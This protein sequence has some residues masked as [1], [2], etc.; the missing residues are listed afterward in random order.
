MN[1]DTN[2]YFESKTG[3]T[4]FQDE[5]VMIR[6]LGDGMQYRARIAGIAVDNDIKIMICEMIDHPRADYPFTHISMPEVC[7]DKEIW[8]S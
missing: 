6:R 2:T 1:K 8:L 3:Q 7:I 4:F 5:K